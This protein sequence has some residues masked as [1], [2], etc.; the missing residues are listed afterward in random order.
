MP[1]RKQLVVFFSF[2]S[3]ATFAQQVNP[4]VHP[5]TI[6]RDPIHRFYSIYG[7]NPD[8]A[9]TPQLYNEIFAWM[10]TRYK[11][12]GNSC[13]GID[14]SG[15]VGAVYRA[16]YCVQLSGGSKDLFTQVD[17]IQRE[18]MQEGDILFFKIRKGQISHVGVY[19][20]KNKFAHASVH[21]GVMISDLN[22]DYYR[23]Y[24][25]CAGRIK[26]PVRLKE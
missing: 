12:A 5:D 2:L 6:I 14:C 17:T 4:H 1:M 18:C 15:F 23:R 19:L 24:F 16:V 21:G 3:L 8:S 25:Y 20:G 7:L 11:Y 13:S 10:G 9:H 22:E 26:Q